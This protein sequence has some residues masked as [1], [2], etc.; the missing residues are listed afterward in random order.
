LILEDNPQTWFTLLAPFRN[1]RAVSAC[2]LEDKNTFAE[3]TAVKRAVTL[4]LSPFTGVSKR[5]S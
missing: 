3:T 4:F 1:V 5:V 2:N